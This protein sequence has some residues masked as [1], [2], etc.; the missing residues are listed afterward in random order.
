MIA[1]VICL[2]PLIAGAAAFAPMQQNGRPSTAVFQ[3]DGTGGWGIGSS[4]ELTPE[5]Y[6][7]GER[8]YFEGFKPMAKGDFMD[9][10]RDDTTSMEDNELEELL[11][12][13]RVAGIKLRKKVKKQQRTEF[14]LADDDLDLS[15]AD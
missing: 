5:E 2:I 11:G 15:V 7:K 14:D 9:Q 8:S 1:R 10:L 6:G 12:V 13:A 3:G 4:R